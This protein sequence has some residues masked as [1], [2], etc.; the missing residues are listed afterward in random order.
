[1]QLND[2]LHLSEL[3]MPQGVEL[4][5]QTKSEEGE[6]GDLAV[7]T[8]HPPERT[9]EEEEEAEAEAQALEAG[10]EEAEEGEVEGEEEGSEGESSEQS[11][12]SGEEPSGDKA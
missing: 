11:G 8:I 12:E 5:T 1:M 3:P 4:L 10:E 2:T 7:A 6:A 9:L